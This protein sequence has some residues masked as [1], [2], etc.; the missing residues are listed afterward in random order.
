M[1]NYI[2]RF[3]ASIKPR[4]YGELVGDSY[5]KVIIYLMILAVIFGGIQGFTSL[6]VVSV[7][8]DSIHETFK[9]EKVNFE[10]KDGRLNFIGSPY[11]I[12]EGQVLLL[13]D[14]D[15]SVSEVDSLRNIT[16]H[17]ELS[18]VFLSDGLMV[19]NGANEYTYRY[20]ELGLDKVSFTNQ[21]IVTAIDNF[22]FIKYF[23]VPILI[24]ANLVSMLLYI[25]MI[26][27]AGLISVKLN[28]QDLPYSLIFKLS[29]YAITLPMV[30]SLIFPLGRYAV[31]IGGIILIFGLNFVISSRKSVNK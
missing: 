4:R 13:V 10:M 25:F 22:G 18:T 15:K 9:D 6:T 27:L 29:I 14:T 28:K 17:K 8:Q 7:I 2:N 12:E 30:V 24:I 20:N 19:K 23:I 1:S 26:S 11:K 3:K 5:S 16:V 31:L 21:S